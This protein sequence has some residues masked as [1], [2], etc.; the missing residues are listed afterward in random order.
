MS[1]FG[2]L[3]VLSFYL[4]VGIFGYSAYKA[5]V[6]PNFLESMGPEKIG[7]G[8]YAFTYLAFLMAATMTF[9]IYYFE[10]RNCWIYFFDL[11]SGKK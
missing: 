11:A 8:F 2:L 6:E 9:P 5:A 4:M 3:F 7:Q 10:A 1:N